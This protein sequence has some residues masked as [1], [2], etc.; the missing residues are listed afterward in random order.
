MLQ[1]GARAR[2]LEVGLLWVHCFT[3]VMHLR[4]SKQSRCWRT[5]VQEIPV[6]PRGDVNARLCYGRHQRA[7]NLLL[8]CRRCNPA[9]R[10]PA[11]AHVAPKAV[12]FCFFHCAA[13]SASIC[14]SPRFTASSC[15]CPSACR[16]RDPP[17]ERN[18]RFSHHRMTTPTETDGGMSGVANCQRQQ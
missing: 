15:S 18:D 12:G 8:I 10:R 6:M 4:K 11:F 2:K 3:D 9:V 17:S 7:A 13:A 16:C 14:S 5:D 1:G